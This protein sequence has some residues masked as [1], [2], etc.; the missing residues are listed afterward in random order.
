MPVVRSTSG[1]RVVMSWAVV[2][3]LLGYGVVQTVITGAKLFG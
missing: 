1:V 3:I 2:V